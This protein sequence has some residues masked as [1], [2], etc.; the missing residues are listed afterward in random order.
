MLCEVGAR[1]LAAIRSSM[2]KVVFARMYVILFHMY[3]S[4]MPYVAMTATY[5][6]Q[7]NL[8]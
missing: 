4:C 6:E 5:V 2:K 1:L 7:F 8:L 3:L